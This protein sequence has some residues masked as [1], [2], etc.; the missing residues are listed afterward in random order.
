MVTHMLN[1]QI[2]TIPHHF[3]EYDTVGNYW[4]DVKTAARRR[5]KSGCRG[6]AIAAMSF[7]SRCTS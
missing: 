7:W 5:S 2:K 3:Q 6:C 4:R 1:I